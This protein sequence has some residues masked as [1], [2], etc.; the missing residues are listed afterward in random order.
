MKNALT[1]QNLTKR[2]EIYNTL[3]E[4]QNGCK[5]QEECTKKCTFYDEGCGCM[6]ANNSTPDTWKI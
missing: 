5:K 1:S 4:I 6:F 2:K 3:K